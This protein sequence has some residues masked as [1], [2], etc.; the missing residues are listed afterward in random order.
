MDKMWDV[1]TNLLNFSKDQLSSK[2]KEE[3]LLVHPL[4]KHGK[5]SESSRVQ[6]FFPKQKENVIKMRYATK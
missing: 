2:S 5:K 6:C 3:D 1:Y 4:E